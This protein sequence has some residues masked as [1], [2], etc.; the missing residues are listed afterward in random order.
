MTV[1]WLLI[2]ARTAPVAEVCV[3]CGGH[4]AQKPLRGVPGEPFALVIPAGSTLC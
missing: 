2:E 4:G 1:E 3:R